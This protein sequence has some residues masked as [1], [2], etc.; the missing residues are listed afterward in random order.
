[1]PV[2]FDQ[3]DQDLY[4]TYYQ[5]EPRERQRRWEELKAA[6]Q[7][8]GNIGTFPRWYE[9]EGDRKL[10]EED[11]LPRGDDGWGQNTSETQRASHQGTKYTGERASQQRVVER[12]TEEKQSG[13]QSFPEKDRTWVDDSVGREAFVRRDVAKIFFG[14]QVGRVQ[15]V[16]ES[17]N[18]FAVGVNF[19]ERPRRDGKYEI[20]DPPKLREAALVVPKDRRVILVDGRPQLTDGFSLP[21]DKAVNEEALA[22]LRAGVATKAAYGNVRAGEIIWPKCQDPKDQALWQK[23]ILANF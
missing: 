23:V 12:E 14:R 15:I 19:C 10:A 11:K 2:G 4:Y 1:M 20:G 7:S 16:G 21:P 6:S 18:F 17:P 13:K 22:S 9:R 3:T 5:F 8:N